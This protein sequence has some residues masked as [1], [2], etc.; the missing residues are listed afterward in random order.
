MFHDLTKANCL[1]SFKKKEPTVP[2][3]SKLGFLPETEGQE[4][5]NLSL[6]VEKKKL[7]EKAARAA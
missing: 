2:S 4:V 5:K 3:V 6:P 1:L 7:I